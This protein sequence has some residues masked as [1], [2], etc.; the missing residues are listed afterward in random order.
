MRG[1]CAFCGRTIAAK[2][3]I[4]FCSDACKMKDYR[5]RKDALVGTPIRN[6]ERLKNAVITKSSQLVEYLCPTCGN[7]YHR[8]GLEPLREYCSDACKQKAYRQR[9]KEHRIPAHARYSD[10]RLQEW[11]T[12]FSAAYAK[13]Y[14]HTWLYE[15][16]T[17]SSPKFN[18]WYIQVGEQ[19]YY[20]GN[21]D[22]L[23]AH[24][25]DYYQNGVS[26][27]AMRRAR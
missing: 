6:T 3:N 11:F 26:N 16:G 7:T 21:R 14:G 18:Q 4:K 23:E 20:M 15:G 12:E 10:K 22:A 19:S 5:R 25:I 17:L 27:A 1:N 2:R 24:L 13:R 9:R 8:S